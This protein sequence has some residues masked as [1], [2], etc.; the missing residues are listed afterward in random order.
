MTYP[1]FAVVILRRR[2]APKNW[3]EAFALRRLPERPRRRTHRRPVAG[4]NHFDAHHP[5]RLLGERLTVVDGH[6][7]RQRLRR[8]GSY[9]PEDV[10]LHFPGFPLIGDLSPEGLPVLLALDGSFDLSA[11]ITGV[12]VSTGCPN[13]TCRPTAATT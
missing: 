6:Q 12:A 8:V 5:E 13:T 3:T 4:I 10:Q 2:T 7:L 1:T 11:A 9:L